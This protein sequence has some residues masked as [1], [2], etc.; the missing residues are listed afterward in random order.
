M[1]LQEYWK[2]IIYEH[3]K[4]KHISSE[5]NDGEIT[6]TKWTKLSDNTSINLNFSFD[7]IE[8]INYDM[9]LKNYEKGT[10]INFNLSFQE[11]KEDLTIPSSECLFNENTWKQWILGSGKVVKNLLAEFANKKEHPLR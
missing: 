4:N 1:S 3:E 5:S 2:R 9:S 8:S 6:L 11:N 7:S 10:E